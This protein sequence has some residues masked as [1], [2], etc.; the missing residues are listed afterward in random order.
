MVKVKLT[1]TDAEGH[2]LG[3][4]S[5]KLTNG[6]ISQAITLTDIIYLVS[7]YNKKIDI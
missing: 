4:R 6:H 2:S 7:S 3:Q 1:L 5:Q